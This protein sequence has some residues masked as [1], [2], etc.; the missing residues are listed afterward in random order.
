MRLR[1]SLALLFA[2][3]HAGWCAPSR[4]AGPLAAPDVS[5]GY[6]IY[7]HGLHVA[8]MQAGYS[9]D[10]IGYRVQIAYHTTGLAGVLWGGHQLSIAEGSWNLAAALP[11]RFEGEGVWRGDQ[12]STVIAYEQGQP[13]VQVL[14]PPADAERDPVPEALQANTIDTLSALAQ[15]LRQVETTGRCESRA[16]TFDGR[17]LAEVSARTAG[18]ETLTATARSPFAG[19]ALR[20]DFEGR[21]LAGFLR[22][23]DQEA[24]RRVQHGSAWLA[25]VAPGGPKVPVR[26]S[27]ETRWFGTTT[28]YWTGRPTE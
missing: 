3:T 2:V 26:I 4:G 28:M 5:A 11:R 1:L 22:G 17:R 8:D 10:P 12:R 24:L 23:E 16:R 18:D 27:F 15:L 21:Q 6:A 9:L 25:P 14:I 7:A 19:P 13:S 20:C